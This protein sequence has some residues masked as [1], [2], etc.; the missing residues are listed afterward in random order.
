MRKGWLRSSLFYCSNIYICMNEYGNFIRRTDLIK[1]LLDRQ[2]LEEET[3]KPNRATQEANKR[4][5]IAYQEML[6]Q[7]IAASVAA[8]MAVGGP[9][10][11]SLHFA[12]GEKGVWF[13]ASDI[14][15]L[16]QDVAGTQP[17][18]AVGQ[19]VGK[20]LDKS[21][22]G[23]H[24][25]AAAND[26]TRP[27]YQIDAEGNPNV[28][29]TKT[30]ATQLY[31]TAIDFRTTDKMTVC[32]GINVLDSSSAGVAIE[33]GTDVNS[34][35]NSGSFLIGAPSSVTDHSLYLRGT[36]VIRAA[37]NN[38]SDGDDIITGLFDISQSTASLELIP[39]LNYVQL[40][41]TSITWT[42]TD[43][44]TGNFGNLPLFIGSRSGLGTPYGGKIYQIVVRG[45]QSTTTQINQF[46][47]WVDSKLGE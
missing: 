3:K 41:G 24:A 42:G 16:F 12:N 6:R 46:E 38:V 15:T 28:T 5:W 35:N 1:N 2:K 44:G 11:P 33:L 32:I 37:V 25:V 14:T 7:E 43:A 40:S 36:Q 34:A 29:F 13:D 8:S 9:V 39:R 26:T 17:V 20:W 10:P 4:R 21:G 45:A 18:T 19:Y 31:T 22:N 30:P 27:K 23:K 47:E